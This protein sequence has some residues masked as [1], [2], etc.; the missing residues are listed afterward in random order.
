MT[1][2]EQYVSFMKT[3]EKLKSVTRT[4]WTAE[5]RRESTAEHSWRLALFAGILANEY[6]ELD[7]AKVLLMCLIHDIGEIEGGDISAAARPDP[8]EKYQE[9]YEAA[10]RIFSKLPSGEKRRFMDLWLEYNQAQTPEAKL[11]KALDKAETIIQHN[12]GANPPGFDYGF[13][14]EYGR[15]YFEG[16]QLLLEIRRLL[17]EETSKKI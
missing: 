6:P 8:G 9:E 10:E 4:A 2:A 13:N 5:G 1:S 16:D 7:L 3:S 14:L 15:D 12:Q 11:V 17:D